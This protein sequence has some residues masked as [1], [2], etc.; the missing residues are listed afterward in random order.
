MY[1]RNYSSVDYITYLLPNNKIYWI[2]R[3]NT[4]S[5]KYNQFIIKIL[6]M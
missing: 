2:I 3:G 6:I 5:K 1:C 4:Y